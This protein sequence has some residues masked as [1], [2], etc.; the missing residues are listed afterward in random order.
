MFKGKRFRLNLQ[1]DGTSLIL[2]WGEFKKDKRAWEAI[3]Q[4]LWAAS[5]VIGKF[6]GNDFLKTERKA[7]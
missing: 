1:D 2:R 3:M 6:K 4:L 5:H 7:K